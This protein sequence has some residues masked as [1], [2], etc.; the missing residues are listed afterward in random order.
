M[1]ATTS[2]AAVPTA[3]MSR[4]LGRVDAIWH[5]DAMAH[6][7]IYAASGGGKTTLAQAMLRGLCQRE[8]VVSFEPKQH[9]D[10][11]WSGD[12][13]QWGK[14]VSRIGPRFGFEG[15]PGGGPN[16]LWYRLAGTPD[17][18]DTARRFAAAMATIQAEG[19]CVVLLDDVVAI[20]RELNAASRGLSLDAQ[21]RGILNLGRSASILAILSSTETSWVAGRSQAGIVWVGATS[22]LP[23][24]RAGA[25]LL[26][27]S[28]RAWY[29][30]TAAV[31]PHTWLYNDNQPG[32]P[33]PLLAT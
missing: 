14:L 30:T 3:Q 16:G 33:G 26:G 4:V 21:V 1:T 2:P 6:Q 12:Q 23:A 27:K 7:I 5:R 29:E 31:L 28:G 19:H 22:G 24:A 25:A 13:D 18:A 17:R 15:E 9:D 11:V 10:P 32:N 20:C 8:R